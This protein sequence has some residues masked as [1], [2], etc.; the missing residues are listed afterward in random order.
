[1]RNLFCLTKCNSGVM[2][3]MF[4]NTL[5]ADI[6]F[7]VHDPLLLIASLASF[8]LILFMTLVFPLISDFIFSR[9]GFLLVNYFTLAAIT[10]VSVIPV[11]IGMVYAYIL[12][13]E[14]DLHI[15]QVIDVTPAGKK[16]FIYYRMTV[17]AFLSF[18]MVLFSIILINPVP[19]EGWLRTLFITVLLSIQSPFVF[20]FIGSL[21]ENKNE[22]ISLSMLYGIFLAAIPFGLLLHHPWNYFAFFSPMYWISCSWVA[23]VSIE[24]L[25]YG[26]ISMIITFGSIMILFRHFLKKNPN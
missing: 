25:I 5:K 15:L 8:L 26:S 13:D 18:I 11:L 20:L 4:I 14:N 16:N 6:K 9:T 12:L 10:I 19:T 21:A 23:S 17:S 7:I 1:V 24:S 2:W 22:G 3:S